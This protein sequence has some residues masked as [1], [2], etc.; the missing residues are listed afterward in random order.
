VFL[1]HSSSIWRRPI[2]SK[3]SVSRAVWACS[4]RARCWPNSGLSS[5]R[6]CFFHCVIRVRCTS[7]SLASWLSV[8]CS[9]L[10]STPIYFWL[11]RTLCGAQMSASE[12]SSLGNRSEPH[13]SEAKGCSG[14][15]YTLCSPGAGHS[16]HASTASPWGSGRYR[17]TLRNKGAAYREFAQI[18]QAFVTQSAEEPSSSSKSRHSPDRASRRC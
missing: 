12:L 9:L 5:S 6:R 2:C 7:Y 18:A 3:C 17:V 1:S 16:H 11:F 8:C 4:S 10:V 15:S 14:G 13:R